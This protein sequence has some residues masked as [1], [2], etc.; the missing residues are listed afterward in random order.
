MNGVRRRTHSDTDIPDRSKEPN[1]RAVDVDRK[2]SEPRVAEL[3]PDRL[4]D[5]QRHVVP[6][7]GDGSYHRPAVSGPGLCAPRAA[8]QRESSLTV[9]QID[10]RRHLSLN[11]PL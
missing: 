10:P 11:P 8:P 7:T 3:A 6:A 1:L 9:T 2:R 4:D 5:N